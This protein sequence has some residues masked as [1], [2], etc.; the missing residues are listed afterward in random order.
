MVIG[1]AELLRDH[2]EAPEAVAHFQLL[3]HAHGAMQLHGFLADVP[4]GVRDLD[5]RRRDRAGALAGVGRRVRLGAGEAGHG[6]RL[7]VADHHVHHAVLQRLEHAD[8]YPELLA[9]LQV[10][11]CGVVRVL[12]RADRLGAQ[13]RGGVVHDFLDERQRSAFLPKQCI[14]SNRHAL[15]GN[16][17]GAQ[18]VHGAVGLERDA[19]RLALHQ[20][21]ADSARVRGTCRD[22]EHLGNRRADHR[23]FPAVELPAAA[24]FPRRRRDL[25]EVVAR[26]LLGLRKRHFQLALDDLRQNA[27]FLRRSTRAGDELRPEADGSEIRLD[28]QRLSEQFHDAHQVDRAAAEPA[29][30][31]RE[32]QPKQPHLGEGAPYLPAP[33]LGRCDDL[34]ARF[35]VVVLA[36]EAPHRVGEQLLFFVVIEVHSPRIALEMMLRWISFE[37]A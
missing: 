36:D 27:V 34:P 28:H 21:Q 3:G 30:V 20:E 10:F 24:R 31:R 11:E 5:L 6:F 37:P 13:E 23:A 33:S 32:R 9:R 29:V 4:A 25:R 18:L 17:R 26:I 16:I 22:D 14:G 7:L 1:V 2:G 8:R 19:F 35:E 12:D 15:E